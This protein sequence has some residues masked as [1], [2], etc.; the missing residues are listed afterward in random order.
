MTTRLHLLVGSLLLTLLFVAGCSG[1]GRIS[2]SSAEQAYQKGMEAY[3]A[4][5]Y[6]R[7]IRYFRGVFS[8]GR[9][10]EYAADAQFQLANAYRERK[11]HYLAATEYRRFTQ[12]YRNDPRLPEAAYQRAMS[13]YQV[14]PQ[15]QLDQSDTRKAV[16]YLQ[17]FVEQ[18]PNH[19]LVSD[20]EERIDE[21]RNKLARKQLEAGELYE[22]RSLY[23]AA[24][25]A[26]ESLFDQYPDTRWADE[27]LLGA[28][29]SYIGFSE[30]SIRAR[31]PER[32]RKAIE[33]YN[34]LTQVF[35]DSPLLG[36]AESLHR[37]AQNQLSALGEGQDNSLAGSD[38]QTGQDAR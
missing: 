6:D 29:R 26:Y 28:I 10:N 20:A 12:L 18:Y 7:A 1:S 14:S 32:L 19:E 33:N 5:K 4:E 3:E 30:Q 36:Q 25:H 23:R 21:L 15:Y 34:R 2:H 11:Q 31:Q 38:E 16:S 24:A 8:Y 37:E 27:A 9:G 17:L 13:Y 22:R 35:P